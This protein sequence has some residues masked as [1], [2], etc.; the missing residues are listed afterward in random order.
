MMV[1]IM[2]VMIMM[3]MIMMVMIMMVMI[4]MVMNGSRI[5]GSGP[6]GWIRV[7]GRTPGDSEVATR[8]PGT[9]NFVPRQGPR[10]LCFGPRIRAQS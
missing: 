6:R 9:K 5:Q 8:S 7:A 10:A 4:M 2:M 1:M 3:V